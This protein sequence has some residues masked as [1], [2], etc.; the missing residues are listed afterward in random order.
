MAAVPTQPDELLADDTLAPYLIA[1]GFAPPDAEITV[2][3]LAGG[4]S[5]IVLMA[6]WNDETIVVKQSLPKLRVQA[7]WNI[8][9]GR[10]LVE[11]DCLEFLGN[12]LTGATPRLVFCDEVRLVLGM[13]AAPPG[14]DLWSE[15]DP[16]GAMAP[17]R[18][19]MAADLLSRLQRRTVD[20]PLVADRFADLMP[21]RQGRIEPYHLASAARHLDVAAAI[22]ADIDRLESTKRVLVHGDFSPKNLVAYPDRMLMLD[23]E[24][25]HFGDPAFDV[26]FMLSHLV[27]GSATRDDVAA[28]RMDAPHRFW[29]LYAQ[30]AG[31]VA[32]PQADVVSE[33]GCLL[34]A[35]VDGKSPMTYLTVDD[36]RDRVRRLGRA[37]LLDPPPS[38]PQALEVAREMLHAN[39]A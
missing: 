1:G 9:R 35:R 3:E 29:D 30:G 22:L 15:A 36:D 32:A 13:T 2:R 11:R 8:D 28:R 37:L 17:A 14:G 19:A 7:N 5:N 21:L 23:F 6:S 39:D 4:V 26:A 27:V 10:L 38:V 33:L 24:V 31:P 18:I 25:A 34:L 16:G 20:D 12:A